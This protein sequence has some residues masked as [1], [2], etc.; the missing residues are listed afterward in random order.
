MPARSESR[1]TEHRAPAASRGTP[2]PARIKS[3]LKTRAYRELKAMILDGRL[4]SGQKLGE[5][6]LAA[7]LDVSR[8]PVREA[9]NL[10][11]QEG[12]VGARPQRGHVVA[13]ADAR[14]AEDLA[15][16]A[17]RAA[18]RAGPETG[19]TGGAATARRRELASPA[20]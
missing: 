14:T 3:S 11:A 15:N 8:T 2:S 13:A 16:R 6:E 9:L 12:L 17:R 20:R 5:R 7:A 19:A 1:R 10:L 18:G 4:R